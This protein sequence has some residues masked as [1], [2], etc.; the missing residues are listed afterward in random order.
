M[1]VFFGLAETLSMMASAKDPSR[2]SP[3]FVVILFSLR[4]LVYLTRGRR[5]RDRGTL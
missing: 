5:G 3:S 1:L 2:S 4:L